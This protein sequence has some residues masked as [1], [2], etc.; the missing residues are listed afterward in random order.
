MIF[1]SCGTFRLND[2]TVLSKFVVFGFSHLEGKNIF[3]MVGIPRIK[4]FLR[5]KDDIESDKLKKGIRDSIIKIMKKRGEEVMMGE[6]D[7][8]GSDYLGLLLNFHLV[9]DNSKSISL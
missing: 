1:I 7:S 6:R 3:E 5:T 4:K 8:Y 9:N 2:I